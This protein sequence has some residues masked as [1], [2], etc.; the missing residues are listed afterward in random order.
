MGA[1]LD[2]ELNLEWELYPA[3]DRP[4]TGTLLDGELDLERE[5]YVAWEVP[6]DPCV[7]W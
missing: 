2:G 5:L 6:F 4:R 3:G 7:Q 1:L